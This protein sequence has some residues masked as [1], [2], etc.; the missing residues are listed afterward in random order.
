MSDTA[1]PPK[2]RSK[3]FAEPRIVDVAHLFEKAPPVALDAE[4]ALLGSMMVDWRVCGDVIQ[5]IGGP[6]DFSHPGHAAIYET[7]I[8]S[9]NQNGA[10]DVVALKQALVDKQMLDQVGGVDYLVELHEMVPSAA[11]APHYA[12]LVREKAVVRRLIESSGLTLDDCYN[13][14]LPAAEL[15]D[16]ASARLFQLQ[17]GRGNDRAES[18]QVLMEEQMRVIDARAGQGH[19]LTG[20]ACGFAD[21]DEMTNGFHGGELIVVGARPSMGKT[22]FLLSVAEHMAVTNQIPVAVFSMEMSKGQL[23]QRILTSRSQVDSQKLRKNMLGR[24]DFSALQ[25]A[26]GELHNAPMYIDDT[27]QLSLMKMRARARRLVVEHGIKA[28]F[29]DYLQLMSEP[30]FQARHEEVAFISRGIKAL[31][32]E[33]DVPIICLAQLNRQVEGRGDSKRPRMSDLKESGGIEQDADAVMLLHR[34]EYYHKGDEEWALNNPDK[35][36]LA[37]VII[38]KQRNGPT[39]V[40]E[41]QFNGA[42]TS[43][44]NRVRHHDG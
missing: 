22:A 2:R 29:V 19:G 42:T 37:E 10:T 12:L 30:G 24:E 7:L 31:A 40:V 21:I 38:D 28:V 4:K 9:Y 16:R 41:L 5:I 32:R 17:D 23:A 44:H 1:A 18:L 33:L 15:L 13:Q 27:P 34:E 43:F 20:L 8:A 26:V 35:V 36:G 25:Q 11:S 6:Q 3:S 39:G 14:N